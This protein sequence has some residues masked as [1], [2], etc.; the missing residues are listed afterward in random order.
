MCF[1]NFS[2]L[3]QDY[4]VLSILSLRPELYDDALSGPELF[5]YPHP[6]NQEG[7]L[8]GSFL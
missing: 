3:V 8:E 2:F 7:I 1:H 5:S 6:V 4:S